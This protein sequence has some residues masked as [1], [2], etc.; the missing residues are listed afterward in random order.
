VVND[1][2]SPP[3]DG[4]KSLAF[5]G[6]AVSVVLWALG[7]AGLDGERRGLRECEV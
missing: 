4:Q 6:P 2:E 5:I 3:E 1:E 7:Y